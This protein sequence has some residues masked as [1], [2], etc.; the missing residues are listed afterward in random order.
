MA[1]E[2]RNN[3]GTHEAH[4]LGRIR[5]SVQR[6]KYGWTMWR[7]VERQGRSVF[8]GKESVRNLIEG[9]AYA[10]NLHRLAYRE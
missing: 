1:L 7:Y 4:Y 8:Y 5:Y 2:W 9:K 3:G 6:E 10:D